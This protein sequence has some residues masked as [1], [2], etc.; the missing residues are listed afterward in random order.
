MKT[1]FYFYLY[2]TVLALALISPGNAFAQATASGTIEGTI[3]DQSQGVIVGAEVVTTNKATGE[4]RTTNTNGVGNYRFDLLSAGTYAVKVS[5]QGFSA[6]V[7]NVDLMVGQTVTANA[8]LVPGTTTQV[9]EI[10]AAAPLV[11]LGKSR[12][13]ER[14]VGKEW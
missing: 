12:S 11:D 14:R 5:R 2:L 9:V 13:E 7:K 8:T 6:Q 10:T 4:K 1:S 3:I